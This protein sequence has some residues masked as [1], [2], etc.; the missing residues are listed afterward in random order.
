LLSPMRVQVVRIVFYLQGQLLALTKTWF[1]PTANVLENILIVVSM[2]FH[3]AINYLQRAYVIVNYYMSRDYR[4]L[5][6]ISKLSVWHM[7]ICNKAVKIM[8]FDSKDKELVTKP[9]NSIFVKGVGSS[10]WKNGSVQSPS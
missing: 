7:I 2:G 8:L 1:A 4:N 3:S 10:G 5:V 6:H 9:I